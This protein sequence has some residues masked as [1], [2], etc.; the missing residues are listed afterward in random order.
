MT[1]RTLTLAFEEDLAVIGVPDVEWGETVKAVI[2]LSGSDTLSLD[3]VIAFTKDR[4]ASYKAP[5]Y[6]SVVD[7]IPHNHLGKIL[8]NDLRRLHGNPDNN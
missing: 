7:E 2:V 1:G 8:K 4:L 6:L 5:Q 3:D